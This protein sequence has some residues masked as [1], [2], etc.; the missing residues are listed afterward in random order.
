M[1]D[2]SNE[3]NI[4]AWVKCSS[5]YSGKKIY[6]KI[7]KQSKCYITVEFKKIYRNGNSKIVKLYKREY[8]N[9]HDWDSEYLYSTVKATT[10]LEVL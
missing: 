7:I 1:T 8:G 2:T 5:I 6:G 3:F 10:E 9:M 4:G